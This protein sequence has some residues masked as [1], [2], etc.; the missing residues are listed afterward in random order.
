MIDGIDQHRYS[1][2][3]GEQDE[4][5][6]LLVAHVTRPGQEL[7][8]Q[9]PFFLGEFDLTNESM[10]VGDEAGHH[11]LQPGIGCLRHAVQHILGNIL[12]GI[13]AHGLLLP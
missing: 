3:V 1:T 5:L 10:K 7:D 4:F 2:D 9:C 11:F 12:L 13:V 8:P 6:A